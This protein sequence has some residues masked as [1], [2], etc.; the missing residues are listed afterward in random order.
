MEPISGN[1]ALVI[2]LLALS[3]IVLGVCIFALIH[4]SWHCPVRLRVKWLLF[5]LLLPVV[6][7][8]VYLVRAKKLR[9]DSL[10]KEQAATS[11][12]PIEPPLLNAFT[13]KGDAV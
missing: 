5:I 9:R 12:T 3:A 10:S 2:T 4:C 6:G 13:S 1:A 8:I 11:Q 7:S